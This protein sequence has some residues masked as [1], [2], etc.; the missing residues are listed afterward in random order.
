MESVK[1]VS[2][3]NA[4]VAGE[5]VEVNKEL[6]ND[7]GLVNRDPEGRGWIAKLKLRNLDDFDT[8][9]DRADYEKFCRTP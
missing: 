9:L 6:E 5:V 4:P 8:L 7:P 1:N 2:D 3:V